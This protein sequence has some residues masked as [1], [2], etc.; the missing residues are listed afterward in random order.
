MNI[1]ATTTN[2]AI[3]ALSSVSG[4]SRGAS[5]GGASADG[6]GPAATAS[7]S[8]RGTF[9]AE[10]SQLKRSDPE[11]FTAKLT[12]M[13]EQARTAAK[14]AT[15][16]DAKAL[17]RTADNLAEVAK[18]GDLSALEPPASG[19]RPT[20][21]GAGGARGTPPG[22]GGGPPGAGGGGAPPSAGASASSSADDSKYEAADTNKD[23]TVSSQEQIAYEAKHPEKAVQGT[24]A[25]IAAGT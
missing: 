9:L 10:L 19:A 16:D 18:S 23:G 7:I 15:G 1:Q 4:V 3:G 20:S 21:G 13:S 22:G 11:A 8:D 6:I 14:G 25:K 24:T 5:A 17:N 12:E 2:L